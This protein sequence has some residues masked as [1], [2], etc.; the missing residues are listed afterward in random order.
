MSSTG[1]TVAVLAG[2][3]SRRF[4][5][6]KA[7]AILHG[8]TMVEHMVAV[9]RLVSSDVIVVVS[10]GKQEA[11][12]QGLVAPARVVVDPEGVDMCPLTGAL[13]AFEY[14]SGQYTALL[15]VDTPLAVPA[16]VRLLVTMAP[17][18]GAVVPSW[19]SG[20]VEPLHGV[21][22]TE[23]AYARGLEV[24]QRGGRKMSD[25]LGALTNVLYVS[26]TVLKQP[27]PD[28]RTFMNINTEDD[29]RAVARLMGAGKG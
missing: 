21:Y 5:S 27:D 17:G 23:H 24:Y 1:P 7:L 20:Y 18:H 10:D 29:L 8:K 28:L 26:T 15:P 6:P 11:G 22:L 2:G 12:L 13:T 9:A 19:P 4:R 3:K 25:L 16:V 14:S